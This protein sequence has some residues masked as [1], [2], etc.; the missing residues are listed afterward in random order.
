[1]WNSVTQFIYHQ[2]IVVAIHGKI[3]KCALDG[4]ELFYSISVEIAK[5]RNNDIIILATLNL[6]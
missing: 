5:G 1:M 2:I 4:Q 6:H 3:N